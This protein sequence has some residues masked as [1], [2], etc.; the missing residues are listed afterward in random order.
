M[1][2]AM[3]AAEDQDFYQNNGISPTGIARAVWVAVKGG[4]ATQGGSTITQQYVKNYF[5]TAD[6][7]LS[8]K[9]REILIAV[10]IDQQ[11]TKDQ[12]LENYLN[13]IYYGRGAYGIQTASKAYFNKD[14]SKLT[15]A[16]S[17]FLAAVI[18]GPSLY[19]PGLGDKQEANAKER[20]GFIL[21]AMV[22]KGWL[23]PAERAD[24]TFPE[25]PRSTSRAPRA[26]RPA[27]S[28]RWSRTRSL[29]KY[30]ITAVR[31]RPRWPAHRLD[32]G[33]AQAGATWSTAVKEERPEKTPSRARRHGLDQAGQRGDRRAVRRRGLR[34]APAERRDPG[35]DAGRLDVQD[36]HP[37]RGAAVR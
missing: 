28:P 11:Q 24:A 22:E 21:D 26:G 14:V 25:V 8:R 18:R 32:G 15:P 12:I 34:Q 10:K 2:K 13:T 30:K 31:H 36:L 17:A 7:T 5:L 23:S 37:D 27:T 6:R 9:A 29:N 1:Q 20:S 33:A 19:D 16:E 3:L 35:Q 4:Q